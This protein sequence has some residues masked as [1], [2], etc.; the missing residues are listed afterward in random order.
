MSPRLKRLR[1]VLSPPTV[2]GFKP[3]GQDVV[4]DKKEPIIIYY[5]EYEAL[6]LCDYDKLNH[7]QASVFMSVSRPTFT[8]VYASVR[9]KIAMAFVES[10]PMLIE[11]GKVY[12]DSDWYHCN[13]CHCYFNNPEKNVAITVCGLCGS[14]DFI[15]FD[16]DNTENY[17]DDD[18]ANDICI[19][20][21]CGLKKQHQLGIPCSEEI[22]PVCQN[23]MKRKRKNEYK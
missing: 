2:K 10:R 12:F 13:T 4:I 5:E 8:R 15:N 3:F 9:Q 6:R 20:P 7:H 19:C 22:C 18:R 17:F 11:G 21:N 1:K 23:V 16:F 14:Q